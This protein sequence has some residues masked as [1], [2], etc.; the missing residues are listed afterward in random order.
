[1]ETGKGQQE[2][3]ST[4]SRGTKDR[5]IAAPRYLELYTGG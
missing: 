5:V 2:E 3:E 1:M 4:A